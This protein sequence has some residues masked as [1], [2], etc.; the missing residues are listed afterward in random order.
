MLLPSIFRDGFF[1]DFMDFPPISGGRRESTLMKSDVKDS[2]D[3]Y[4]L[5]IDLPGFKKEDVK[6]QLKEGV[7]SIEASTQNE[8]EDKDD[9]GKYLRR[10]RFQGTCTRQ[11][12]LGDDVKMEDISAKFED[13]VL[14]VDIKKPEEKPQIEENN[15]IAIE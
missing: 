4:E 9:D 1:D 14:K 7:L 12:Y 15:Y 2:G 8:K 11:F 3:H 5:Q 13:G 10:E 6:M